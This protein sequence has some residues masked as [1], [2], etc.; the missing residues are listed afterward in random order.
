MAST[1]WPTVNVALMYWP[2]KIAPVGIGNLG[3]HQKRAGLRVDLVVDE[4]RLAHVGMGALAL[5]K[6]VDGDSP[7]FLERGRNGK[8]VRGRQQIEPHRVKL[9]D[10]DK[11]R[12]PGLAHQVAKL[13]LQLADPPIDRRSTSRN[14]RD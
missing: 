12:G 6:H 7:S 2:G 13:D 5:D 11:I 4:D 14:S 8:S 10:V 1:Y 3:T 9:L